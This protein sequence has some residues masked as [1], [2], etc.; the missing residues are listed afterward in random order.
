MELGTMLGAGQATSRVYGVE[1]LL[2]ATRAQ[3]DRLT[4]AETIREVN[5]GAILIDIR[6]IEQRQAEG[7]VPGA[8]IVQRNV[9][10]WRLDPSCPYRDPALAQRGRRVILICREGYQSSLAAAEVQRFGID[11]ADVIGGVLSWRDAGL[12]LI[13]PVAA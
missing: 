1:D 8:H 13:R 7:D 6:P 3:I 10:E 5:A 4:P 11:A 12:T 9:L 2:A